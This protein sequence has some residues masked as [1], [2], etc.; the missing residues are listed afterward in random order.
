[1]AGSKRL[2]LLDTNIIIEAVRTGCWNGLRGHYDGSAVG[3]DV[4]DAFDG[5]SFGRD[6]FPQPGLLTQRDADY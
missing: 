5:R 3:A 1:M 2:I 4:V 6:S